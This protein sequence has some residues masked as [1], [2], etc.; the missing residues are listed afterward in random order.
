VA[1]SE[2]TLEVGIPAHGLDVSAA[3][4]TGASRAGTQT[5][6]S[7]GYALRFEQTQGRYEGGAL[8]DLARFTVDV[9]D[10]QGHPLSGVRLRAPLHLRL[11]YGTHELDTLNAASL[12]L[13]WPQTGSDAN[14]VA[15]GTCR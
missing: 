13:V 8:V 10:G 14:H 15:R 6:A 1:S 12:R 9:L 3:A 5:S 2:G 7:G 4:E 11:H